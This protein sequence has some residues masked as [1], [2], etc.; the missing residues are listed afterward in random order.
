MTPWRT[1][2]PIMRWH[3]YQSPLPCAR[4][5]ACRSTG[6]LPVTPAGFQSAEAFAIGAWLRNS[7]GNERATRSNEASRRYARTPTGKMPVLLMI[8]T[9]RRRITITRGG[10]QRQTQRLERSVRSR[11]TLCRHVALF[12]ADFLYAEGHTVLVLV[13]PRFTGESSCTKF[14]R[15]ARSDRRRHLL[16]A[17]RRFCFTIAGGRSTR[18]RRREIISS[19]IACHVSNPVDRSIPHFWCMLGPSVGDQP[20][21]RK[22]G[23]GRHSRTGRSHRLSFVR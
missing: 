18:I 10:P 15:A 22:E 4:M 5:K 12:C 21:A 19:S 7:G 3:S 13:Q 9:R 1:K 6:I 17:N 8:E 2:E 11:S 23:A 20:F 14:H 16:S